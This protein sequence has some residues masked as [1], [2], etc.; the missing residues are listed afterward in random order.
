MRKHRDFPIITGIE[1]WSVTM[2]LVEPYSIAYESVAETTNVFLRLLTN[3]NIAGYGCAAPDRE[4]RV[5]TAADVRKVIRNI[6]EPL[7][8]REIA[9]P[10]TPLSAQLASALQGKAATL[11]MIEMALLDLL[12]TV[13][14]SIEVPVM[15]D[16]S[17][18]SPADLQVVIAGK[19]ASIVNIKL[20]KEG[21]INACNS[22]GVYGQSCRYWGDG[23]CMDEAALAIAA[24]VHW[25]LA[26]DG[27]RYADLD[28]HLDLIDDP[29]SGA[30]I[31]KDGL[32]YTTRRVGLGFDWDPNQ[33]QEKRG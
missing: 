30:V 23:R 20:M 21:G 33:T 22:N 8:H 4:V 18:P 10:A 1:A 5:E 12:A 27:V 6:A 14:R 31:L 2:R 9:D 25:A 16:E 3:R 15:A 7:L 32:L 19:C 11:A 29:S 28:G 24:A 26:R 13:S 17:V